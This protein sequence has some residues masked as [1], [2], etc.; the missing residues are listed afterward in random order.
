MRGAGGG[1][2]GG[3]GRNV[4]AICT[5]SKRDT[6]GIPNKRDPQSMDVGISDRRC[7]AEDSELQGLEDR[8]RRFS[9]RRFHSEQ[10]SRVCRS[11]RLWPGSQAQAVSKTA[12]LPRAAGLSL[13]D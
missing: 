4:T 3:G 6:T 9:G 1:G 11:L 7:Q 12:E 13:A 10:L 8:C 5:P 2:G